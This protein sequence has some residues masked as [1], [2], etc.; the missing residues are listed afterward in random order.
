MLPNPTDVAAAGAEINPTDPSDGIRRTCVDFIYQEDAQTYLDADPSDPSH[1][2][3][4]G[5][6]LAC[7]ALP[8]DPTRATAESTAPAPASSP[9]ATSAPTAIPDPLAPDPSTYGQISPVTGLPRTHPVQGYVRSDG[10]VVHGY[11]RSCSRCS[12]P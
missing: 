10:T 7:E 2:D 5:N 9:S 3:R 1:L 11:Y 12:G 4:D 8:H 6:G